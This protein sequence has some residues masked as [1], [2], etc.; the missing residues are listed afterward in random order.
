MK[1]LQYIQPAVSDQ[2]R[3]RNSPDKTSPVSTSAH[4]A[5][6]HTFKKLPDAADF[7]IVMGLKWLLGKNCCKLADRQLFVAELN[8]PFNSE[9]H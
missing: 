2:A 8:K 4:R 3:Q 9:Q 6:T 1:L 7:E 5:R